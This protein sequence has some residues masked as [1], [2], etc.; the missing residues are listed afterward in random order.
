VVLPN[1]SNIVP[2]ARQVGAQTAKQV[3]VVVTTSVPAGLAALIGYDPD[4]SADANAA[5]M[6]DAADAVLAGE[7]TRAVRATTSPIV[8][9]HAAA[10]TAVTRPVVTSAE[11]RRSIGR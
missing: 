8:R 7:V 2:V 4:A 6:S 9:Q 10:T 5:S 3:E 1:N 11:S